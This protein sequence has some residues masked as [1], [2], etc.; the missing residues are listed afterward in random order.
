MNNST[1]N[2]EDAVDG[3]DQDLW[4]ITVGGGYGSFFFR[5]SE[6]EAEEM[7]RHKA[8]WEQA[9]ARKR[10]ATPGEVMANA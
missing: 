10:R 3:A 6:K 4:V 7:R 2:I 1:Q 9:V 8:R 5:G